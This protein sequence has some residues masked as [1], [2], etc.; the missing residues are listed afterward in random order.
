[1]PKPPRERAARALCNLDGNIPDITFQ[2]SPMW[3][4]YLPQVDAVLRVAL[5][6]EAW[7]AMVE[8]EKG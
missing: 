3:V 4:S 1:M 7:A 2:G 5:G 6:D 8:G